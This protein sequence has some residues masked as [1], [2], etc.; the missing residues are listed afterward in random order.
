[1]TRPTVD[2]GEVEI[3]LFALTALVGT[4]VALRALPTSPIFHVV[5]THVIPW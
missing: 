5:R 1:M 4:T 3:E 2:S